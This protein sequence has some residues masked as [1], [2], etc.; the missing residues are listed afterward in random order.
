V[1][2]NGA[3]DEIADEDAAIA[4]ETV[5][6]AVALGE[7]LRQRYA[8]KAAEFG[9]TAVQAKVLSRLS[10]DKPRSM[11]AIAV[12]LH[13]DPANLTAIVDK[14]EA[15]G[16][17]ERHEAVGD[18]R[19]K[20]LVITPEGARTCSAFHAALAAAPG[21]FEGLPADRVRLLRDLLR[22]ILGEEPA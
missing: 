9:L 12:N 4:R 6:L 7:R 3:S 11:R 17:I 2:L 16:L 8:T 22:E 5:S 10:A 20:A 15:R 19:A 21:P 18:R 14:L 13:V 1:G